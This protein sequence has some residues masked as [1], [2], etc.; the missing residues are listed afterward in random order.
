MFIDKRNSFPLSPYKINFSGIHL[1]F[2]LQL[3]FFAN[4]QHMNKLFATVNE[5]QCRMQ[6][7]NSVIA[8]KEQ[9]RS[10]W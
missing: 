9:N 2:S 5:L 6:G 4:L 7:I 3:K 8:D 10:V 1:S